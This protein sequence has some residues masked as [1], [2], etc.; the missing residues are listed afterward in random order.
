VLVRL[1][2][3]RPFQVGAMTLL[4]LLAAGAFALYSALRGRRPGK[5]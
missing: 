4:A 2:D 1:T 5:G 3:A